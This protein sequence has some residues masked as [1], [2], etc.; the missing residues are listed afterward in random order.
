MANITF[1]SN[2]EEI[3]DAIRGAIGRDVY[4]YIIDTTTP[5]G[6]CNLDPVTN[7]STNSFC[8]TCSGNFWIYTYSGV[9]IS[10]HVFHGPQ[11]FAN[12]QT[13]GIL[14]EGDCRVQIKY[15]PEHVTVLDQTKWVEVDDR[16]YS[17]ENI[18]PRGVKDINR[19][20][21]N[22]QEEGN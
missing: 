22:L 16:R 4:F 14:Y 15:T 2:T 19:L 10:G 1:P 12:W 8:P 5:C 7:T 9:S 21:I 11:D 18:A 17:I 6:V 13:G 3:I 20:I